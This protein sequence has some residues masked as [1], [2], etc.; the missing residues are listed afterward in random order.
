MVLGSLFS[1]LAI[2][3]DTPIPCWSALNPREWTSAF[4]K[5]TRITVLRKDIEK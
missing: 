4:R 3:R 5:N 2:F 1:V